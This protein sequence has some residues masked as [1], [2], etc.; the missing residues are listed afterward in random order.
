MCK[1]IFNKNVFVT[2]AVSLSLAVLALSLFAYMQLLSYMD[3]AHMVSE[4]SNMLAARYDDYVRFI[5]DTDID[6]IKQADSLRKKLNKDTSELMLGV[7]IANDL[8]NLKIGDVNISFEDEM[9]DI[10][11]SEQDINMSIRTVYMT[12]SASLD[13]VFKYM[14]KLMDNEEYYFN[15][16]YFEIHM[17][18]QGTY[19]LSLSLDI[20]SLD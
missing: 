20:Y 11:E 13:I 19:T 7:S 10:S 17:N 18:S 2:I 1:S 3:K 5:T 8:D 15:I 14:Q 16:E 9:Q 12:F 6:V 4:K